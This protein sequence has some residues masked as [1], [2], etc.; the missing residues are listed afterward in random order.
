M[1]VVGNRNLDGTA[2]RNA[3]RKSWAHIRPALFIIED[4]KTLPV[5]PPG[6]PCAKSL[7]NS[8]LGCEATGN[9]GNH[10]WFL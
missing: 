4:L 10:L 1:T 3:L 6:K 8:L 2:S 7:D 5:N 9:T